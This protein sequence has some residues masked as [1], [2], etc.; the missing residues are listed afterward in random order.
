MKADYLFISDIY[1]AGEKPLHGINASKLV[2]DISKKGAKKVY[3]LRNLNNLNSALSSFYEEENIIIFM[4]AV[5]ISLCANNLM[6][7]MRV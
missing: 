4:G 6:E 1:S 5:S 7:E 3:Y 2:K